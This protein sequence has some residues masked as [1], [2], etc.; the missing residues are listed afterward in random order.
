MCFSLSL[1]PHSFS[2]SHCLLP[3]DRSYLACSPWMWPRPWDKDTDQRTWGWAPCQWDTPAAPACTATTQR[4]SLTHTHA[5]RGDDNRK[6]DTKPEQKWLIA[7]LQIKYS[8]SGEPLCAVFGHFS[9]WGEKKGLGQP[10]SAQK[11]R[12]GLPNDGGH[13][14]ISARECAATGPPV[15]PAEAAASPHRALTASAA[16][17]ECH[18]LP[19]VMCSLHTS[20]HT[21]CVCLLKPASDV[22]KAYETKAPVQ[23]FNRH[24]WSCYDP[25]QGFFL[26]SLDCRAANELNGDLHEW[27]CGLVIAIKKDINT[28]LMWQWKNKIQ[29]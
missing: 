6:E 3:C 12:D 27:N 24:S 22:H 7:A 23:I 8:W 15:G 28:S 4:R 29:Q 26:R 13:K 9:L 17:A 10:V 5:H 2:L 16:E 11:V 1:P 21:L 19:P 14:S 20:K 18:H 25:H